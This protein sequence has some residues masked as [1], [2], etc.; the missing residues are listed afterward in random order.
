MEW[1]RPSMKYDGGGGG[2]EDYHRNVFTC[3]KHQEKI[4]NR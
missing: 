4:L 1:I 3:E 2:G